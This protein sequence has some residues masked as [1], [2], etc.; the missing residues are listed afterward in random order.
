ML[1]GVFILN[2]CYT[3]CKHGAVAGVSIISV[4]F[5]TL[6]GVWNLYYYP[7]LNQWCSFYGG[8]LLVVANFIWITLLYHFRHELT[9]RNK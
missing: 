1:S 7:S 6:W 5:F 4:A 8:I 9:I 2:N 3:V